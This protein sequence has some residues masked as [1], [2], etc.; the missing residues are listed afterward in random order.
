MFKII[1]VAFAVGLLFT[2][3]VGPDKNR[4]P[5]V[6]I[7]SCPETAKVKTEVAISVVATDRDRDRIAYQVA[8]GDG[9]QSEWSE[10]LE[11]GVAK[12]FIHTYEKR[13][14]F[15]VYAIASDE[16]RKNSGWSE[17]TC[18]E[19]V[20]SQI[21]PERVMFCIG[22][23]DDFAK[24]AELGITVIQSYELPYL[25]L[26]KFDRIEKSEFNLFSSIRNAINYLDRA[27][28][29]NLKV[30][31]SIASMVHNEILA[32][33]SWNRNDVAEIIERC[34]NHP[35]LYCWQPIE[36]ANLWNRDISF[37]Q[38]KDIYNFFKAR[39]PNHPVTQTLAGGTK[40]WDKIDFEA[41]DFL[42]ADTYVYNGTGQMWGLEPLDYL[43][44]VAREE[45][46]YL[47]ENDVEMAVIFVF[48]CCDEP[49]VSA[50][51][52]DTRVP[53]DHIQEQFEIL[54][55][56]GLFTGGVG[57]WAWNGGYFGPCTS[58]EMYQELKNLLEKIEGR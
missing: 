54:Q 10:L 34:K 17:K 56:Y 1:L 33:G 45:R 39:D 35:A 58:S 11:S 6:A 16:H 44:I 43:R 37:E 31:Y 55:E 13:G 14:T 51:N 4:A 29:A 15:G 41:M 7:V 26:S 48:Q 23:D 49:A 24:I 52:Y 2:G 12:T 40:D 20:E 46:L 8:F 9:V 38:Q 27:K 47:D 32:T 53:L 57:F 25:G 22:P 18:I 42:I 30:Y 21:G 50:G 36:E 5:S 3:C 28:D 19:V